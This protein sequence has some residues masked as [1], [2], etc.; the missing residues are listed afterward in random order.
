M[1]MLENEMKRT[2]MSCVKCGG[3]A[4]VI[5]THQDGETITRT[6]LCE[7]CECRFKTIEYIVSQDRDLT[8]N[9]G[10]AEE[11]TTKGDNHEN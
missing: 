10:G 3:R 11:Q 2:S 7:S 1:V 9:N 6:R 4:L 5:D 8:T